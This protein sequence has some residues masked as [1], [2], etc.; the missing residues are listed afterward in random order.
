MRLRLWHAADGT[1]VAYREAAAGPALDL[2]HY[3]I[4]YDDPV[5]LARGLI[6]FGG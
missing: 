6:A 2:L 5:G 3:L 4:A 1:R